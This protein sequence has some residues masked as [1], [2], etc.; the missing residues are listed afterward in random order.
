M[1]AQVAAVAALLAACGRRGI[2]PPPGCVPGAAAPCACV[3]GRPGAQTCLA[4]R[5]YE[6][7]VCAAPHAPEA[8]TAPPPD[9]APPQPMMRPRIARPAPRP[10]QRTTPAPDAARPLVTFGAPPRDAADCGM[11]GALC[12]RAT[13]PPCR[14]DFV[15]DHGVCA[16]NTS[17][18]RAH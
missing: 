3:D 13:A 11:F 6:P 12:C 7:C 10:T 5:T 4:D 1:R 17:A 16:L 15:C 2:D 9:A 14:E 8:P 18:N